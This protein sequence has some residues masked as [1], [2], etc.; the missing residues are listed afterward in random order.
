[1]SADQLIST[2]ICEDL[3]DVLDMFRSKFW[4]SFVA[5]QITTRLTS[6]NRR[7]ALPQAA[8]D[9]YTYVFERNQDGRKQR[10]YDGMPGN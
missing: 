8:E 3:R 2:G 7:H 1:M 6:N 5:M 4:V 10:G 9:F